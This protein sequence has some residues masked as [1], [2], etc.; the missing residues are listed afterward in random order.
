VI[1]F[2]NQ[3]GGTQTA[4]REFILMLLRN[5]ISVGT[6][7]ISDHDSDLPNG[8]EW[9]SR[10]PFSSRGNLVAKAWRLVAASA[11]ARAF[12]PDIFVSVGISNSANFVARILGS[13]C[14]RI[15]QDVIFGRPMTDRSLQLTLQSFDALAPQAPSMEKWLRHDGLE[16]ATIRWLPCLPG[17]Q[18]RPEPNKLGISKPYRLGYFG[19]IAPHKGIDLLIEAISREPIRSNVTLDV[20]G[21]GDIETLDR[22]IRDHEIGGVVR[23]MGRYPSGS[24]ALRLMGNY[25]GITLTSTGNEGLPLVLLEA[26]ST[27]RP[28]LATDVAAIRDCCLK[29]PDAILIKPTVE[30]IYSGLL[31]MIKKLEGQEFCP[32]RQQDFYEKNFGQHAMEKRWIA[33]LTNPEQFFSYVE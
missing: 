24:A 7:S 17:I 6:I 30:D 11:R 22:R 4:Y 5:G 19:R 29:N 10:V 2:N 28:I 13:S 26:M 16:S 33:C 9:H 21:T 8:V 25:D 1:G 32:I 31:E 14:Y 12:R 27:G 20:W 18:G 23:L 15:C 3:I